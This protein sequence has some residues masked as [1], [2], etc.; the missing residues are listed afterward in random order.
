M[1][2]DL[3]L[4]PSL[5]SPKTKKSLFANSIRLLGHEA[6]VL[7]CVFSRCGE[8]AASAGQDRS[9]FLWDVFDPQCRNLGVLKGHG[10]TILDLAWDVDTAILYS[11]SADHTARV[12][13]ISTGQRLRKLKAH[14]DIV[15]AID[16]MPHG[17]ELLASASD[18]GSVLLW[19]LR[20]REI[21]ADIAM[22]FP[23]TS[24]AFGKTVEGGYVFF[25]GLDNTIKAYNLRKGEIE[26]ELLGHHDTITGLAL[27]RS[28]NYLLSNSMDMTMK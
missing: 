9:I 20:Q 14:A 21:I 13:D 16:I 6:E 5:P 1:D 4:A 22:D 28:G 3:V 24:V 7:A 8:Y 10:H 11:A 26:Y 2:T 15:N 23:I 17:S 19:D 27:S 25:G 18:D 12:W